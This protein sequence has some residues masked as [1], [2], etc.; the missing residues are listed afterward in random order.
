MGVQQ[1]GCSRTFSFPPESRSPVVQIGIGGSDLG[2]RALYIAL[3]DWAET[4]GKEYVPAS[5]I[6]NV[7]P[8]DP[9]STL[10]TLDA[11]ETLFILVSKSGTTLETLTNQRFVEAWLKKRNPAIE[12]SKHIVAVT[13]KSSPLAKSEGLQIL[14]HR[15]LYR[16]QILLHKRH[17]RG[18]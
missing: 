8:D 13:S 3:K 9:S 4:E 7:D 16:R 17:R 10:S 15:R 14:L 18:H 11:E 5:F 1:R 2:P 6:S 12:P